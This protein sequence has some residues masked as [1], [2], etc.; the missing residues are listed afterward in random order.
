MGVAE[1]GGIIL[2][3]RHELRLTQEEV[4]NRVGVHANYIGYLER[5]MRRPSDRTLIALSRA[6]DLDKAT[7]FVTLNPMF[8]DVVRAGG[9]TPETP[10]PQALR[11]LLE[12]D[13]LMRDLGASQPE[14]ERLRVLAVFGEI[15]DKHDY[16]RIYRTIRE[17]TQ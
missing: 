4:G 5:G 1:F 6:L 16:A 11:D 15:R 12:D 17:I 14:I 2:H 10:L 7:L 9:E 8:E 3:R 13:Q